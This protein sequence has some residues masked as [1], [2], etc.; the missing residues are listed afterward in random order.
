[1]KF[2]LKILTDHPI[3][4]DGA[5][6]GLAEGDVL[7]FYDSIWGMVNRLHF[8]LFTFENR[9]V[10]DVADAATGLMKG[11]VID[12]DLVGDFPANSTR[13]AAAEENDISA[14]S[15]VW[16]THAFFS[17]PTLM[18]KVLLL[19]SVLWTQ[20]L[21]CDAFKTI[22]GC[23]NLSFVY[24]VEQVYT[25]KTVPVT[26]YETIVDKDFINIDVDFK[27][28]SISGELTDV[29]I[30]IFPNPA[31]DVITIE[32]GE[33][34]KE[35]SN[36]YI[37]ITNTTGQKFFESNINKQTFEIDTRLLGTSGVYFI[38][39][40]DKDKIPVETRKLLIE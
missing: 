11:S 10:I 39:I 36:Y 16:G 26:I 27:A 12:E 25:N 32:T 37:K 6:E 7:H 8:Q 4:G 35:I 30:K 9:E 19:N 38:S 18:Y 20:H 40:L 5:I 31:N 21:E 22:T 29:S 15:V 23:D 3:F 17:E 14:R 2:E 34:F 24:D 13:M 1:M 28:L 33:N